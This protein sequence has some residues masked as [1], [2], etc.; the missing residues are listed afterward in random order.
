MQVNIRY[1]GHP[2][3]RILEF[4]SFAFILSMVTKAINIAVEHVVASDTATP[5][6]RGPAGADELGR[7]AQ[8][9]NL[10]LCGVAKVGRRQNDGRQKITARLG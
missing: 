7:W 1:T 4:K 10:S 8:R 6:L 9:V 2:G 5:P 3:E